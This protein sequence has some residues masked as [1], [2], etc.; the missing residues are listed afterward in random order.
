[1]PPIRVAL[2]FGSVVASNGDYCGDVVNVAA[3]LVAHADPGT[4]VATADVVSAMGAS[5]RAEQL[6]ARALKGFAEPVT[7]FRLL[8]REDPP[9]GDWSRIAG[10]GNGG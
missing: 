1:M 5:A 2:T 4:A 8:R 6:P 10:S 7:A 9:V 3:R